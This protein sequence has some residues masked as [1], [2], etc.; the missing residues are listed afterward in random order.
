MLIV[1]EIIKVVGILGAVFLG[2]WLNYRFGKFKHQMN[3]RMDQLLAATR[4][5]GKAEGV[6]EEKEKQEIKTSL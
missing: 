3:S 2:W 5:E 4:A 1:I 6:A